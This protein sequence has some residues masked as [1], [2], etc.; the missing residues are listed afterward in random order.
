MPQSWRP[1]RGQNVQ[2]RNRFDRAWVSGFEVVER[3]DEAVGPRYRLRRR[4]D[5]RLLPTV[6]DVGE[7]RPER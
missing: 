6:F 5:A 3:R 7:L 4:C 1:A 2:V